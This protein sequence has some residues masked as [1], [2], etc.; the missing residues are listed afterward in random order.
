LVVDERQ[1]LCGGVRV[2]LL[3]GGQDRG[4]VAHAVEDNRPEGGGQERTSDDRVCALRSARRGRASRSAQRAE[5]R[6]ADVRVE[7]HGGRVPQGSARPPVQQQGVSRTQA[8]VTAWY[9]PSQ[10]QPLVT[11]IIP[12][13]GTCTSAATVRLRLS[14]GSLLMP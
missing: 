3:D 8:S 2:A 12:S 10:A 6:H 9:S 1:Q 7:S 14:A 4:D 5:G 11:C 13:A